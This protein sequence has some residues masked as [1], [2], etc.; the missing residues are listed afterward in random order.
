MHGL[1]TAFYRYGWLTPALLP[2]ANIAG[3]GVF[4]TLFYTYAVWGMLVLASA[5]PRIDQGYLLS[6]ALLL[7]LFL[8]ALP[9]APDLA[10][11]L[12]TWATFLLYSLTGLFTLH[13]L[14]QNDNAAG[15]L[16]TLGILAGITLVTLYLHFAYALGLPDYDPTRHLKEDNLPFLF[17]FLAAWLWLVLPP[18]WRLTGVALVGLA[19]LFY[20]IAAKGRAALLGWIIAA[21]VTA[22][23]VWRF[24]WRRV[25]LVALSILALMLLVNSEG[26]LRGALM[27]ADPWEKLDAF[28]SMRTQLWRQAIAHPPDNLWIGVGIGNVEH[29]A[30]VIVI[31]EGAR[32]R[33]LHNFLFDVWYE[34]GLL[35]LGALLGLLG[36]VFFRAWR[37]WPAMSPNAQRQAG[38]FAAASLAI[39]AT[40][41]LSISY[42]S[43]H[44]SIYLFLCLGAL[45]HLSRAHPSASSARRS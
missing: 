6:Y 9:I 41:L 30:D 2:L 33:G 8:L 4:N 38:A 44:F 31:A 14:R 7:C 25:V 3:R 35:G 36:Y 16:R 39:L 19:V 11:G 27:E 12:K 21:C 10:G 5:R 13:A 32:M 17:P 18:R 34:T 45:L 42:T 22:A 24:P 29:F 23:L 1:R 15:L 26:L 40:G 28:T 20:L 37:A 43:R